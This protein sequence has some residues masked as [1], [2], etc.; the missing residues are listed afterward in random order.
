MVVLGIDPGTVR[1]GY[2]VIRQEG[3]DYSHVSSGLFSITETDLSCRLLCLDREL[4]ILLKKVRPEIA[5]VEQVYFYKNEKTAISVAHARGVILCGLARYGIP[6]IHLSPPE[7]KLGVTGS[8]RADKAS[9][10]KMVEQFLGLTMKGKIDDVTD[11]LAVAIVASGRR[12]EFL[13]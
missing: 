7:V 11:A 1:V 4:D 13:S 5:G 8:G 10:A 2:G 12:R 3:G 9:V 6:V